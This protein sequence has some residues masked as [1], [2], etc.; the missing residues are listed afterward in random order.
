M[1]KN[2]NPPE[3][4]KKKGKSQPDRSYQNCFLQNQSVWINSVS[5]KVL[6]EIL[7]EQD[8]PH[9]GSPFIQLDEPSD[10]T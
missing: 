10:Y 5:Q 7:G 8:L 4:K 1:N 6:N 3:G 2:G 9:Q